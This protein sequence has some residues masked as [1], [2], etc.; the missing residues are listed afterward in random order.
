MEDGWVWRGVDQN[1]GYMH[2][3]VKW[4]KPRLTKLIN[5][6]IRQC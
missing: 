6:L 4:A 2:A 3:N 5:N 1:G